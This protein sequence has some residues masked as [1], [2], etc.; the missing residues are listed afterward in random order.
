MATVAEQL[1]EARRVFEETAGLVP[2]IEAI[3]TLAVETLRAGRTIFACGN[4]GSCADA[5]H[6]VEE[7][8]GRY[9]GDRRPLPAVCLGADA[10]AM[11]CIANDFGYEEVF[12][13]P[14]R[15]LGRAGDMVVGFSTSGNSPTVVKVFEA[16]GAL[17]VRRV[18]LSGG[19]GGAAGR[20]AERCL[21]VSSRNT[22]RIQEV[23][24]FV[25]HAI[26]E[27]VEMAFPP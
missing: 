21:L 4:G 3:A 10:P 17:G 24:G 13:R 14:L 22:A 5:L 26:L 6:L 23:H 2:E 9:R 25:L 12:A 11:T 19:D 27:A 18:L 1:D 16:A 8:V 7:L 20:L 15:A